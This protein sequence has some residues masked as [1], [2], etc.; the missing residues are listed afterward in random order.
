MI[1]IQIFVEYVVPTVALIALGGYLEY[2][3][4]SKAAAE[5]AALKASV[6]SLH[7]KAD[8]V[9]AAVDAKI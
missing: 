9:K 7:A 5:V 1:F 2:K 4:G 6:A 3:F 8:A